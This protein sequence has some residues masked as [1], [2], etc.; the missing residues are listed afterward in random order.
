[1]GSAE[2]GTPTAGHFSAGEM[3]HTAIGSRVRVFQE[4]DMEV[5]PGGRSEGMV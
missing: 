4:Q 1:V 2:I 5:S 3:I